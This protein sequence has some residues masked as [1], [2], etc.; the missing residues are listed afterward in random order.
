MI[1]KKIIFRALGILLFIQGGFLLLCAAISFYYKEDDSIAFLC[2]IGATLS[3]AV[4]FYY[5]GRGAKRS[6]NRR[7]GYVI[8]ASAWIISS[9][10]GMLPYLISGYIEGVCDAFFEAIS[11]FTSTGAT[12][13]D[14]IESFPHGL[15]FWRSITQWIGGLGI[16]F[17]TIAVLPMIGTGGVKLFAA[18][19]TGPTHDKVHPRIGVTAKWIW[20]IYIGSTLSQAVLLYFSGMGIFDSACHALTTCSTGGFSTKQTSIAYFHSPRIEYIT[21]VFMLMSGVN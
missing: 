14:R 4:L 16:V 21:V 20:M 15:L 8:V 17:F 12:I 7:D 10:I 3:V 18:E 1:N 19:A 9:V 13:V 2:S 6:I 11:G 5:R